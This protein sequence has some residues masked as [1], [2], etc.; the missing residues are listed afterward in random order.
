MASTVSISQPSFTGLADFAP[1][2]FGQ[3]F[4]ANGDYS[5]VAID[6]YISSSS[7]G[8]DGTLRIYDFNSSLPALGTSILGTGTFFEA[9]LSL[10]PA[11]VRITLLSPIVVTKGNEFA[12]TIVAKDPG[13][14]ATGW[15]N[16]GVNSSDV[17]PGGSRITVDPVTMKTTDLAFQVVT[18]PEPSIVG[19]A[20]V[21]LFIGINRRTRRRS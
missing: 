12:F 17:Y 19:I 11:W 4:T 21:G 2:G 15:N 7:G 10:A 18:I 5:I 8:S 1:S 14:S 9:D 20:A 6:L 16:Y 13:G 3:S